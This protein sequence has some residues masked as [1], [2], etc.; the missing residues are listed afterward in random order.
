MKPLI[1]ALMIAAAAYAGDSL[2]TLNAAITK[3]WNQ[4]ADSVLAEYDGKYDVLVQQARKVFGEDITDR[5]LTKQERKRVLDIYDRAA[6]A[7]A[8]RNEAAEVYGRKARDAKGSDVNL[9]QLLHA[10]RLG[11]QFKYAA[12]VAMK[13]AYRVDI[14]VK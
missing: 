1:S 7:L 8:N 2:P 11:S 13:Q 10:C 4:E 9:A 3:Q 5:V 6:V 12:E 14:D